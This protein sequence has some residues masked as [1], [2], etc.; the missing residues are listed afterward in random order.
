MFSERNAKNIPKNF[1]KAFLNFMKTQRRKD[2]STW[3]LL[4]REIDKV[5]T[6]KTF[7][8]ITIKKIMQ[9]ACLYPFFK[10]FL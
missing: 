2:G 4:V 10:V 3:E 6:L 5:E 9:N 7:N 8:N 1:V